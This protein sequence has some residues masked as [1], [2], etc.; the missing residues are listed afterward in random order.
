MATTPTDLADI[1]LPVRAVDELRSVNV[2]EYIDDQG[3]DVGRTWWTDTLREHGFDDSLCGETICRADIFA[4]ADAAVEDA[5]AALALL[6]NCLA[7]GSGRGR[8]NNKA[9]VA[10]VAADREVATRSLQEAARRSR[11]SPADAY[12]LLFPR[13][14]TAIASLGPAFFTKYLYFA[15]GGSP[16]HPCNIL[17]E[18]VAYALKETCGWATLPL[19]SWYATTYGRYA[20]VLARW[21]DEHKLGRLDLIERW[22]FEEGKRLKQPTEKGR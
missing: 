5:G 20:Q 13:N 1:H 12:D 9:R 3:F 22:L 19:N 4:V 8:R 15:G 7:W 21:V 14:T 6:W 10:A 2:K 11:E 18:N 17:D 16:H